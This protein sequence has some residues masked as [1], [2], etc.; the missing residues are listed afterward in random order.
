L[1]RVKPLQRNAST[2]AADQ[3]AYRPELITDEEPRYLRRQKPVEIRRKKFSGKAWPSYRRTIVWVC[4]GVAAITAGVF[5]TRYL[6]YSSQMLLLKP[7]QIEV[8]GNNIVQ[9]EE[10]VKLFVHDRERSVVRIPLDTRRSQIEELS[11]VQEANVQRI[12]PNH[13]RVQIVERTPVA[14]F[15]N[16]TELTLIDAHGVL[17]DRPEG[18]DF[19]FP[20]VT[21]LSESMPREEREKRMGI[22]TEFMKDIDLVRP[23]SSDRV[24]EIELGN[25]RD[26]RA[27]LTGLGGGQDAEAV[28]VHFG[29]D[30][31]TGKYRM[32][33]ENFAQWQAN[34]GKVQSIDLQYSR[35]V[36]VNPDNSVVAA[37]KKKR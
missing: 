8:S 9:R 22:Y 33:V 15:R 2:A 37:A 32:L 19:H 14:F 20:I 28:T 10:I 18:E 21:G 11:W 13:L 23:G 16:G 29:R 35:Q 26:L 36:V 34:A 30:D 17:L 6:L 1:E 7:D 3:E 31:F 27:V 5:A 25:P 12:L 24:S 4:A